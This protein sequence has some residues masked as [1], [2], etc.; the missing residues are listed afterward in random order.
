[1]EENNIKNTYPIKI[2]IYP[3]SNSQIILWIFSTLLFSF[4]LFLIIPFF[5]F[6][7][8]PEGLMDIA[9]LWI[10]G[11]FLIPIIFICVLVFVGIKKILNL[12][13]AIIDTENI[14]I[15]YKFL[16]NKNFEEKLPNCIGCIVCERPY[17]A[18]GRRFYP[19]IKCII[20]KFNQNRFLTICS[21]LDFNN[22]DQLVNL[23]KEKNI[24]IIEGGSVFR[25]DEFGTNEKE[26]KKLLD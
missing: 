16:K 6:K 4:S 24:K 8:I 5:I 25:I 3:N 11:F 14:K 13:T 2:R 10:I 26:L 12:K 7:V 22:F 19:K 15:N 17:R 18:T 20:L 9:N 23:L 1:M 21:E